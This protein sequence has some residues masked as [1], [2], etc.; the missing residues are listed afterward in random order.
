VTA[1]ELVT[2]REVTLKFAV[3]E[4][5]V[6]V[7]LVGTVA[8]FVLLLDSV[9]TAPPLGAALERVTVP[10]EV[11]PLVTLVGFN[12]SEDKLAGGGGGGTGLTVSDA[13]RV[14][15][16]KEPEM[17][18]LLVAVT[19]AVLMLKVALVTPAGT[20]TLAGV[21]ATLGALL[22]SVTIAP[23]LWAA[24]LKVTVPCDVLPPTRLAG[25]RLTDDRDSVTGAACGVN[26]RED[27]QLPATPAELRAR[28]RHQCRTLASPVTVICDAVE[29]R[30]R[31]SG[32]VKPLLSSIWMS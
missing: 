13:V 22:E 1:V 11:L 3:V 18:T 20:V 29:V 4:P 30:L 25:F 23:P 32:V 21:E 16:P 6:T 12:V 9:T 5:A 27:D 15:P 14:V 7:T 8:A 10:C 19:V 2:V 24:L 26:R 17:V 28:T 31:T